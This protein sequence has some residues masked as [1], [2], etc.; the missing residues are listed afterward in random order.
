[1]KID[2]LWLH[3]Y[4]TKLLA[5]KRE[6]IDEAKV[7]YNYH[8]KSK[9]IR[10]IVILNKTAHDN[11]LF[12]FLEDKL[13]MLSPSGQQ[14]Y[15]VLNDKIVSAKEMRHTPKQL[16]A[17]IAKAYAFLERGYKKIKGASG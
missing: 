4:D 8:K 15:F 9:T 14:P 16:E 7:Q 3:S 6:T 17:F 2:S 13:V 1:M 5:K 10:C 11:L 12:F